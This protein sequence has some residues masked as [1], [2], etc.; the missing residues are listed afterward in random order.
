MTSHQPVM[1]QE[2]LSALSPE[3]GLYID[4]T[5]GGGGY[6]RALL[7]YSQALQVIGID[8]DDQAISQG[9][10]C[11]AHEIAQGRLVLFCK[12]F[13]S[14]KRITQDFSEP[15]L[16]IVF[17]LGVSSDQIDTPERGF[18][19]LREGPLDMRMG[20]CERSAEDFVNTAPEEKIAFV[21]KTFG[22]EKFARKIARKIVA[23]RKE[24]PLT[25]T[26]ALSK[27][28]EDVLPYK[29]T[30]IHPATRTFQALRIWV[31]SELQE[32]KDGLKEAAEILAPK[33][34]LV[35]VSFHSLEDRI[36]KQFFRPHLK[37]F[38]SRHTLEPSLPPPPLT[39]RGP[40]KPFYPTGEEIE[41]NPRA[42]SARL[43]WGEKEV[44]V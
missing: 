2:V 41:H 10:K 9:Q 15:I 19:F 17:D 11:F 5:F 6:T 7:N 12:R 36:V 28:V 34:R 44:S 39:F 14:L 33:G 27:L 13:S 37:S 29:N 43:R 16:G 1:C 24:A 4:A 23:Y 22:E 18:S 21:L 20:L 31:N 38:H 8:R 32:L 25:T 3:K 42:R 30:R 35:V 26:T 40:K